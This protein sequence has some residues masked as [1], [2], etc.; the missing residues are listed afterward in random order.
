[1]RGR[2][3][4][5]IIILLVV[6]AAVVGALVLLGGNG[7]DTADQAD[8]TEGTTDGEV[9]DE[10]STEG[11]DDSLESP[12][13]EDEDEDEPIPPPIEIQTA[14]VVVAVQDLPRG[15]RLEEQFLSGGSPAVGVVFWPIDS[16][17][18]DGYQD[19]ALLTNLIVRADIPR[20]TPILSTQ[21]VADGTALGAVGSDAAILLDPGQVAVSVP[22]DPAG[23]NFAAR[24]PQPGD[25]VDV[26]LSFLFIE[27]DETFQ[28]R[29]PNLI[30]V[31]TRNEEGDL[32]FGDAIEGRAEPDRKSV[33]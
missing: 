16:I 24:S 17:P 4:I 10:G 2:I 27:V 31:I 12:P 21:L 9:T 5:L 13:D 19:P 11:D 6:V 23:I 14:P 22:L 20:G 28:S 26:I 32:T 1:M 3:V 25:Q 15:F 18:A 29:Q 33:V 8:T 7:D 30:S